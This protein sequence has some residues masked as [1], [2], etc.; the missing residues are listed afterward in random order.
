MTSPSMGSLFSGGGGWD[1]GG[2]MVGLQ[3]RFAVESERWIATWHRRV[4][5][6]NTRNASVADV[7]YREEAMSLGPLSVLVSSPPCQATSKSGKGQATRRARAGIVARD[8]GVCDPSVGIFSLDAVEA[9]TPKV[10]L[11]ENNAGYEDGATFR[12]IVSGL[13]T[14]G[15]DVDHRVLDAEDFGVASS[16][17]RLI[18][19][20]ARGVKLPEWPTKEA[21]VSWDVAIG[22]LIETMPVDELAPW[23][24]KALVD[25]PPPKGVPLLIA[26]GNVTRNRNG[27]IVHR[28]PG[29]HAWTT[30]LA[31]NTSG[32]RVVDA[33][34]TSR[35]I[36]TRALA[37]L[38]G[39][40]DVYPVEELTRSEAIHVLGNSVPTQFAAKLLR[41]FVGLL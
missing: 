12:A 18:L 16:R 22:D 15:Y 13:K 39:F 6:G 37:R 34:G 14:F 29:E 17:E 10:F 4:F 19:R 32:M 11:L 41:P 8:R 36:T 9:F 38:Q 5:G 31:A 28:V 20:A 24:A 25:N 7:N 27:Y 21:P 2:V 23:Q 33:N 26:G 1:Q 30:Q 35:R 3:P 40:P